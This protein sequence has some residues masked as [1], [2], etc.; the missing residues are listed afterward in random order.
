MR[1]WLVTTLLAAAAT[2]TLVVSCTKDKDKTDTPG[3]NYDRGAMLSN[4]ADNYLTPAYADMAT[5]MAQLKT[6][7]EAFVAAPDTAKLIALR[8]S[9]VQ[10]YTTWQGVEILEFGPEASISLRDYF[11]IYPVSVTK[12]NNNIASSTYDLEQFVNK[13]AQGFPALDYLLN[14][15]ATTNAG[16]TAMYTTDA[17]AT[18]R[19]QYLSAIVTKMNTKIVAVKDAWATYKSGFTANTST[20]AGSSMS[21]MTNAFMLYYERYVRA[22]KIGLPVGA[23]SGVAA[24]ELTE[25]YYYPTLSKE[26]A[27]VALN[28][29]IA[30]YEGRGYNNGADGQGFKDYL[31][32]VATKDN[33]GKLMADV[34]STE[35]AEAKAELAS[36]PSPI[37]NAVTTN[38]ADVLK[39]YEQMQQLVPLL[40]VDMVSAFGISIT[41]TDND[42]D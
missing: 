23:M 11:N 5:K 6:D 3:S 10:A 41:Y 36:M 7:A 30:W 32:A 4:Y 18:A 12:V 1:K 28:S 9:W 38:R 40:K 25:S 31:T 37:R 21:V 24:P 35:F 20:N 2:T 29:V 13:D 34:I 42:G 27:I 26:L 8:A 16:I 19:K 22:G 33:T 39:V 14:G 17:A 15:I